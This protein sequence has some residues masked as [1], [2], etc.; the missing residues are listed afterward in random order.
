MTSTVVRTP[1]HVLAP[2]TGPCHG[3]TTALPSRCPAPAFLSTAGGSH[4]LPRINARAATPQLVAPSPSQTA[5]GGSVKEEP[6]GKKK[7]GKKKGW[8]VDQVVESKAA[9]LPKPD[10]GLGAGR[11]GGGEGEGTAEEVAAFVEEL[12]TN[13]GFPGEDAG[14]R[15]GGP[16]RQAAAHGGLFAAGQGGEGSWR[17]SL[18]YCSP[19]MCLHF[20]CTYKLGVW[21]V[22]C[23][24]SHTNTLLL[25][26]S[27][28]MGPEQDVTLKQSNYLSRVL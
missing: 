15:Q 20:L 22:Y 8:E 10:V 17:F 18:M 4:G 24:N 19:S 25:H 28:R 21:Y 3:G 23:L 7:K 26:S 11:K 16:G 27:F 2:I 9:V 13:T 6:K 14:G 12:V 5:V 1:L